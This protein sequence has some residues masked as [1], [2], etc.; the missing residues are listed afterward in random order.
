ML[1]LIARQFTIVAVISL[2]GG[3]QLKEAPWLYRPVSEVVEATWVAIAR[4]TEVRD[5][6]TGLG[7]D[8]V[9]FEIVRILRGPKFSRAGAGGHG[10]KSG[11]K[12]GD[13]F[14]VS[15]SRSSVL[16]DKPF[17]P[18]MVPPVA[19]IDAVVNGM[20]RIDIMEDGLALFKGSQSTH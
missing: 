17:P 15:L 20:T 14:L 3:T 1:S 7:G 5:E 19:K 16:V 12:I 9:T 18:F 10:W 6:P 13:L 8:Y 4:V 11:A 2:D